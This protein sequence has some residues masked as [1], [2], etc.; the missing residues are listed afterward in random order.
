M[1]ARNWSNKQH[2]VKN[3]RHQQ[4]YSIWCVTMSVQISNHALCCAFVSFQLHTNL[5]WLIQLSLR[6][7]ILLSRNVGH[8]GGAEISSYTQYVELHHMGHWCYLHRGQVLKAQ[9]VSAHAEWNV[10]TERPHQRNLQCIIQK[11]N[12]R[13]AWGQ[14]I[15]TGRTCSTLC[16]KYLRQFGFG[17]I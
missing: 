10:D 2:W 1:A 4:N 13:T 3:I 5:L 12:Q 15:S 8:N 11:L 16:G 7:Y 14:G 9:S 6:V 17:L